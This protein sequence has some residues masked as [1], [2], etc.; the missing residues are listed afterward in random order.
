MGKNEYTGA[1]GSLTLASMAGILLIAACLRAPITAV[2]PLIGEI[3]EHAG[4]SNVLAGLLI[5]LP[6]LA[7]GIMSMVTPKLAKRFGIEMTLLASLL[8]LTIG[9]AARSL[10]YTA[11]L[12]AGTMMLGFAIAVD[13][14]L[15]P[16][17]IK[18]DYPLRVGMMTGSYTVTMSTFAGLAS[19]VSVPLALHWQLGWRL[20][21]LVWGLLSAAAFLVW[22]PRVRSIRLPKVA[23]AS[24]ASAKPPKRSSLLRSGLAWKVTLFM[25]LQS[26]LFY[27]TIAWLPDIL[28][29]RGMSEA[30]A[31]WML[32]LMQFVSLPASFFLP[33]LASRRRS[34]RSLVI[35]IEIASIVGFG[36]LLTSGPVALWVCLLGLSQGAN[37]SLGLTFFALRTRNAAQASELSGMGQSIGYLIAAAGPV[38]LGYLHDATGSWPLILWLMVAASALVLLAGV[39]AGRDTFI[40]EAQSADRREESESAEALTP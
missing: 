17:L 16:A 35:V 14:V 30:S 13:N 5:S 37:I 38:L 25:G 12:F 20:S 11:A 40:P 32:S 26:L 9:I 31:G 24:A 19:G 10:P 15:L 33:I 23:I 22:I 8:V 4:L 1:R 27:V 34:Q 18:R 7:F 3:R 2:G 6:P 29:A 28:Q 36:G 39:G 21:L